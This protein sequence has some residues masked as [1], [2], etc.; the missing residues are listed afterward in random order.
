MTAELEALERWAR[1]CG[2]IRGYPDQDHAAEWR[3]A[4]MSPLDVDI[5]HI[6]TS[7][8]WNTDPLTALLWANAV[9]SGVDGLA[10]S[11]CEAA[12]REYVERKSSTCQSDRVKL[13]ALVVGEG[14]RIEGDHGAYLSIAIDRT[15]NGDQRAR[16][17]LAVAA[18]LLLGQGEPLGEWIAAWLRGECPACDG[19]CSICDHTSGHMDGYGCSDCMNTGHLCANPCETCHGHGVLLGAHV[20]AMI[21]GLFA[22]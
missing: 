14:W 13:L 19:Q 22:V 11:V 17:A 18:D 9:E 2:L 21:A 3:V 6:A 20:D 10:L 12:P 4:I 8:R 5:Q 16:E 15:G 7:S 1:G